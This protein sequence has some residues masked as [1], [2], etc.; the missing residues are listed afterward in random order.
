MSNNL[1]IDQIFPKAIFNSYAGA[2]SF[3][4]TCK[5]PAKGKPVRGTF[6]MFKEGTTFVLTRTGY[7]KANHPILHIYPDD[8]VE[9]VADLSTIVTFPLSFTLPAVI[10]M[11]IDRVS[12]GK[13]RVYHGYSI[14]SDPERAWSHQYNWWYRKGKREAQEYFKGVRFDLTTGKCLNPKKDMCKRIN[15]DNRKVW[16]AAKKAFDIGIRTRI[17]I[18]VFDSLIRT[19]N[20]KGYYSDSDL[21]LD[22]HK[23]ML[24]GTFT[25]ELMRKLAA[26]MSRYEGDHKRQWATYSALMDRQSIWFRTQYGVFYDEIQAAERATA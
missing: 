15:P 18:G 24:D 20:K 6:R 5:T 25:D 22:I 2:E 8:T 26:G 1:S 13:Y 7:G 10:P 12:T 19:D 14:T 9:F 21:A 11:G 16:L 17:R 3:F 23:N 4:R